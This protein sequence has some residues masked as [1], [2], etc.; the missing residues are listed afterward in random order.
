MPAL[1]MGSPARIKNGI[2]MSVNMSSPVKNCKGAIERRPTPLPIRRSPTTPAIPNVNPIG[3][4]ITNIA[5]NTIRTE[6]II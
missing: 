2:A 4:P 5:K 6:T 1:F 3:T